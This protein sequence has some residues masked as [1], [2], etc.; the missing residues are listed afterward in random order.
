MDESATEE[1]KCDEEI[2][3]RIAEYEKDVER[4]KVIVSLK[5]GLRPVGIPH[6]QEGP[7]SGQ[8]PLSPT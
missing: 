1:K 6:A 5:S 8:E 7:L 4:G 2:A 3:S